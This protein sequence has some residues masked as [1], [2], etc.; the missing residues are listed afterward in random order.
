MS[1]LKSSWLKVLGRLLLASAVLLTIAPWVY[2]AAP[3]G[4]SGNVNVMNP[5]GMQ[6]FQHE[7]TVTIVIPSGS[8]GNISDSGEISI[9]E[10]KRLVIE[11]ISITATMPGPTAP[12]AVPSVNISAYLSTVD[13]RVSYPIV[14]TKYSEGPST[15][16]YNGAQ[17]MRLYADYAPEGLTLIANTGEGISP[18]QPGTANFSIRVSGYFINL[19]P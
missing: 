4:I 9:P 11:Y 14:L 1:R 10:G 12:E 5:L 2:A 13:E 3:G 8:S 16:Y 17:S 15:V 7:E 19:V 6:A 18:P